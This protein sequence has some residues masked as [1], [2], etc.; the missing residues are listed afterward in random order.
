MGKRKNATHAAQS[1]R[2]AGGHLQGALQRE[3]YCEVLC[4]ARGEACSGRERPPK[5][6]IG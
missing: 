1:A 6:G 2:A 3:G 4:M 5:Q